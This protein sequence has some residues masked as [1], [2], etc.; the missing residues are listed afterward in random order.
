VDLALAWQ[1]TGRL[2][3]AL[4]VDNLLDS[5]YHEAIGFPAPGIRPRLTARYRFGD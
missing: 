5:A 4:A 2:R 1:A 3:L